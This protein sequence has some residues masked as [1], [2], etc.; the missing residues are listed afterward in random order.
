MR[1][2]HRDRAILAATSAIVGRA[3]AVQF[4]ESK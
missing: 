4:K 3:A 1:R 2:S